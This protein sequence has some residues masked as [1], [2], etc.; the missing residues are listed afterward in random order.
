MHNLAKA[1]LIIAA[2]PILLFLSSIVYW[3]YQNKFNK[4]YLDN[5]ARRRGF[6][7]EFFGYIFWN[8]LGFIM[9]LFGLTLDI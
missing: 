2:C 4:E 1:A 9:S 7:D 8:G 3:I 5:I 6:F